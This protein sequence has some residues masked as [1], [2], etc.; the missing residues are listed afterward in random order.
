MNQTEPQAQTDIK[1][2][3]PA[4]RRH[5]AEL[6]RLI[7]AQCA[8][9]G[10]SIAKVARTHGLNANL[11]HKWRTASV[12]RSAAQ[13]LTSPSPSPSPSLSFIPVAI[14]PTPTPTPTPPPLPA[15]NAAQPNI[16]IELRRGPAHVTVSWPLAGAEQC[17]AWMRELVK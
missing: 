4:R 7:L 2:Q 14:A 16:R 15:Q 9:P 13:A 10:A 5:S 3:N 17:A 1:S 12:T 8:E 6:K 11:V